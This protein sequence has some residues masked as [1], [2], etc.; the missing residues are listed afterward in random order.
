MP[1]EPTV[2]WALLPRATG[3]RTVSAKWRDQAGNWSPVVS[4]TVQVKSSSRNR[5]G[6]DDRVGFGHIALVRPC[7]DPGRVDRSR[8]ARPAS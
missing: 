8:R 3:L 6:P 4:D 1:Y 5:R 7:P 2:D